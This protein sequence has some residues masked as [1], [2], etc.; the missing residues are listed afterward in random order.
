MK[1]IRLLT[2][3]PT[4]VPERLS[5]R[6]ARPI[7]H[8]RSPEFEAVFGRVREGLGWLFQTKQDVLVFAASGTG[9]MEAAF[10]NFLRKGD[11]AVV[12][13]GGKFGERWGKFAK[14]YGVNAV[15]LKCEWGHPVDPAAVTS[16]LRENPQA[17]AVYVQAN[18]SSTGVYHP[19]RELAQV[20]AKTGAILVVDAIS[21]LGAM[22]L[23]MDEWGIDVLVSAGHKALGL[24]P[25]I[26][27]LAAGEKAWKL[28]ESADLPR[29]YFDIKREREN[30]RKNQTAWT[31]AIALVEG[32]DE[33]LAMFREEGLENVFA[34]HERMAR[35][36][37][38]GM[39]ALG[40]TLYSKSP[41]SAMTTVVA[42]D[43]VD[44]E[45]LVKH[46]FNRYG[47]KLVGGQD[48]AKGRV[49]RIAHLGYFDDF[50]MLVVIGAVERGLHDLGARVELGAGL[51]AAQQSFAGG[52]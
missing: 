8:H 41:S 45:K 7:V 35:A 51:A 37:R 25:G 17:K 14:A 26:A 2:P 20:T 29:F 47:I 42:P 18:E 46:L 31:P 10:V 40:L 24:P 23:P 21:A 15:T 34:R 50:D 28:N 30:Q 43:G 11:T 27:F 48:G 1:K 4:P 12:V 13:D 19:I 22:T 36:A 16:A 5:L 33:S 49:F 44:S 39:Q 38:A 3:G 52:R 32:L 9:A 6:M